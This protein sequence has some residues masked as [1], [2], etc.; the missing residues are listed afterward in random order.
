MTKQ[1]VNNPVALIEVD[2]EGL[3]NT[4]NAIVDIYLKVKQMQ[5]KYYEGELLDV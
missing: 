5:L 4:E 1:L 3:R 2:H